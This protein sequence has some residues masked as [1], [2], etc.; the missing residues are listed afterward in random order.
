M[1][2]F[3]RSWCCEMHT[4]RFTRSQCSEIRIKFG[5][6][7]RARVA[8]SAQTL[9][10]EP[11]R[12]RGLLKPKLSVAAVSMAEAGNRPPKTEAM[13]RGYA[14]A[15][16]LDEDDLVEL[17]WALQGMVEIEDW[18]EERRVQRW[19][20]QLP[21]ED[22]QVEIDYHQADSKAKALWT[23][24]EE[25]YAPSLELITL[26]DAICVI[27]RRLLGDSWAVVYKP[28]IGRRDPIDGHLAV[29]MIELRAG[30]SEEGAARTS[31][32]S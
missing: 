14:A 27:L 7:L 6:G 3:T 17:W 4:T 20:R 11:S 30:D 25:T 28:E 15:L 32:P 8:G 13:V 23:P 5:G 31:P 29:V 1:V 26:S 19:W 16:E 10:E 21:A 18:A 24:N 9:V 2:Y 22:P 12:C